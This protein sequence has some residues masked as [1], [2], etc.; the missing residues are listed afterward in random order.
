MFEEMRSI[1]QEWKLE[2]CYKETK[3]SEWVFTIKYW[4][5]RMIE[6]Y[7]GKL[8]SYTKTYALTDKNLLIP[9]LK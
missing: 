9:R 2:D 3:T 6:R 5:D 1:L 7:K 4:E 8:V